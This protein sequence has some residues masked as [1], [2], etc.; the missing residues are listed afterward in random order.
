[1]DVVN[2]QALAAENQS[3]PYI[4]FS[5]PS[6][7][8]EKTK[9]DV[10]SDREGWAETAEWRSAQG[11]SVVFVSVYARVSYNR[12]FMR[13]YVQP[14]EKRIYDT[15]GSNA[16]VLGAESR[17][18]IEKGFYEYQLYSLNGIQCA[19]LQS[20]WGDKS[21]G[22]IDVVRGAEK[23]DTIVGNHMLQVNFC[24][25]HKQEMRSKDVTEVLSNIDLRD[26]YWS[27]NWFEGGSNTNNLN[28]SGTYRSEISNNLRR[29]FKDT[30]IKVQLAQSG[31]KITG[32]FIGAKGDISGEIDDNTVRFSA[33]PPYG[34][35]TISGKW[36]FTTGY[37]EAAGDAG[38][39]VTKGY[40]NLKRVE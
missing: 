8:L 18:N 40:W 32:A 39:H 7:S 31:S 19:Y 38:Y 23:S 16:V 37:K 27:Q 26:A 4:T 14:L 6:Y 2:K 17:V 36:I 29:F 25:Q 10:K 33:K 13:S 9:T 3:Q 15:T 35:W 30:N 34:N 5:F 28:V 1:M 12:V 24:D 11:E 21:F 20:Y 22:G